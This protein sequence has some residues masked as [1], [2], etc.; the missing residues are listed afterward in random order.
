[1]PSPISIVIADDHP[2]MRVGIRLRLEQEP[3][4]QVV[5]EA[6]DGAEAIQ[7]VEK[8]QPHVLLLD[9][10]MPN[11]NGIEVLER[12]VPLKLATRILMLS[13]Y[14]S[15]HYVFKALDLGVAGYLDKRASLETILEA[16][17]GVARGEQGWFSREV[18]ALLFNYKLQKHEAPRLDQLLTERERDILAAA[19]AGMSN[20]TIATSFSISL[21]TVRK[22]LTNIYD[23]LGVGDR[24]EAIAWAWK[25][26]FALNA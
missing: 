25:N 3:D 16:I 9:M 22:H 12:L 17:R 15:Q 24:S 18:S 10:E 21:H 5:G 4:L 26:G 6:G 11:V 19:A 23:K 7:L 13:G 8:F 2:M 1:M 14:N 20:E